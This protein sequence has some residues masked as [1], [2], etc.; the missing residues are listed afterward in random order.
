LSDESLGAQRLE[1][2]CQTPAHRIPDPE[3]AARFIERVGIATLFPASPEVPNLFHA[4]TGDPDAPTSSE[5]DSPAGHVY[6]WRWDLGR[7]EAAFYS[8]IVRK[9]P[10][11]VSWEVLPAILR[12]RGELRTPDEL[13]DLG[14]LSA[15]AYRIAQALEESGGVL[16]TGDLRREAGF[17]TGKEHRAAYLKAVE[18]LD[19]RLLLAKVFSRDDLDM[20]H[21]LVAVRYPEHVEAAERLSREEA[22]DRLLQT[23]L[24]HAVYAAPTVLGRHLGVEEGELRMGL[25][26]LAERGLARPVAVSG[27][28]D[29][30]YA[31]LGSSGDDGRGLTC[32]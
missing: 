5:W 10:T 15:N 9:R 26:S 31:W 28:R 3:T 19:T 24:P 30:C 12:L 2:W 14:A 32:D 20:R 16:S 11:W 8:A 23:Y 25:D 18:E 6:G 1:S 13:F 7:Q 4:Y 29:S 27:Y 22:L 17:P 21:A